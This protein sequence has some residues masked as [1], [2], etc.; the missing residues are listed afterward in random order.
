MSDPRTEPAAPSV[1]HP[2]DPERGVACMSSSAPSGHGEDLPAYDYEFSV[3]PAEHGWESAVYEVFRHVPRICI[4]ATENQF[5]AFRSS[6]ERS[7]LTL[8]ETTRIPHHEPE[9]VR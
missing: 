8:R 2:L 6:L 9:P 7:G 5:R 1:I 3:W 4:P